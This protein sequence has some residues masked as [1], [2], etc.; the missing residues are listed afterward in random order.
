MRKN[1]NDKFP[2]DEF[3]NSRIEEILEKCYT[4][5]DRQDEAFQQGK[6]VVWYRSTNDKAR[7]VPFNT[8]KYSEYF[9]KNIVNGHNSG[10]V[11]L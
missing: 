9:E 7:F 6:I 4:A 11:R 1:F 10:R 3:F 5:F 2:G 8:N